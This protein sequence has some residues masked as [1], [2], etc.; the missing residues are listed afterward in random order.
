MKSAQRSTQNSDVSQFGA[1]IVSTKTPVHYT[2]VA[3]FLHWAIAILIIMM[4]IFG[5]GFDDLKTSDELAFSLQGHSTL[6]FTVITL[7][8][9]RILWRLG[10][11][12]PALPETVA[13]TQVM[14]SKLS[15]LLLYALMIYVPATGIYTAAAHEY[16]VL[17]YG[18][19]DVRDAFSFLG[20]SDFDGRRFLHEIGTWLLIALL[21]VH[22]LAA[23]LHQFVQKDGVLRRMLPGKPN[24]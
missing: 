5:Q 15:H 23:F 1:N 10:N 12:P 14:L 3:K 17:P 18:A 6:G 9:L 7:L 20:A 13:P 16:A 11:P 21:V 19:F 4:L 2:G 22:I 24:S 8:V